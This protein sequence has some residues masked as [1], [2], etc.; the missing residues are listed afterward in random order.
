MNRRYISLDCE[1][2]GIGIE[3]SLLTVYLEVLDE[4]LDMLDS[5]DL[6]IK[7]NDSIYH[8]TAEALGI[9]KI[10][11]VK[12][13]KVAIVEKAAGQM[14]Y[15]FLDTLSANGT[16]KL[17]PL[18][19]N[20]QFDIKFLQAHLISQGTWEKFVSY[21]VRDTGVLG[22]SMLDA[23]LIPS[24][25]SGS[26]TSYCQYFGIN[27]VDAH[28]ASGDVKATIAVYKKMLEVLRK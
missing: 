27:L 20:V 28:T 4:K 6:T 22:N 1:T 17:M 14:L 21:R 15:K 25:V 3:K 11:L 18:G 5:L 12:H 19:Q 8:C 9:N 7:P 16:I 23:G 24:T 26:L 2:G 13:D 10:D